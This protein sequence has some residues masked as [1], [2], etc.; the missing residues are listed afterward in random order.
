M[1]HRTHQDARV[2][3]GSTFRPLLDDRGRPIRRLNRA[4]LVRAARSDNPGLSMLAARLRVAIKSECRRNTPDRVILMISLI[5]GV[6]F[7]YGVAGAIA[8]SVLGVRGAG[9]GLLVLITLILVANRVYHWYVRRGALG[10]IA[11]TA[12]AEGACGS[13]AFSLEGAV[14]DADDR[15]VCPECGAAWR[16][17]RIVSPFW[18]KPVFPVLRWSLT[19]WLTPG[20][21]GR[22]SLYAPDDRGR[23]I[24]S[25][26][27]RLMM[28]RPELLAELDPGEAAAI[29]RS[30]RRVGRGWRVFLML[31]FSWL[32]TSVLYLCWFLYD[33]GERLAVWV[34]L[35]GIAA[36]IL[37]TV[38]CI[39]LGSAFGGPHRTA[40]VIVRHGRCGSCLHAL[41][42][43]PA[44]AE[45]RRVCVRCGAAWLP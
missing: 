18:E 36:P 31:G 22:G 16:R 2:G 40:R 23:Y 43:A 28:V 7:I 37:L 27:S 30:M 38:L 45:G 24:Q 1:T 33:E 34:I 44:D 9:I 17:E 19:A 5:L 13:C 15:V 4:D 39:P 25:P 41:S 3:L 12:V 32:P 10:Q 8:A 11:R 26:D 6:F 21:R 29:R 42:D 20:S 14:T 35:F